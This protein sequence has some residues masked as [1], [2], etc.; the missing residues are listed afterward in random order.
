MPRFLNT[1]TG[2][3]EW[4]SDPKNA[5]Y[6]ILSH[7]WRDAK[8]GGE[9]T[10]DD[11]RRIQE[12]VRGGRPPATNPSPTV[13]R[14]EDTI[15]AHPDLSDKIK[16][17]CK[18]AREAGFDWAWN[19][20]CCI[21]KTS[22]AELSEAINS[23]YEL[24]KFSDVC[25]V[26]LADVHHESNGNIKSLFRKSRWHKRGWT[27][28][29]L[30]AP[31]RVEFLTRDWTFLGTKI[32]L[33]RTLSNITGVDVNILT[34]RA[35]VDSASVAQRML[36]A[37][38]RETTRI[39]DRSYSLMGLF[40][41][42]MPTI[43]GEGPNAF[44]RLQEE[45]LRTVPDHSLFIW[46]GYVR[47]PSLIFHKEHH[48]QR[49]MAQ[50]DFIIP[51][52]LDWECEDEYKV[53]LL[54][55]G[56]E[57]ANWG[58]GLL[59][60]TDPGTLRVLWL[61][62]D[63]SEKYEIQLPNDVDKGRH[64]GF[65]PVEPLSDVLFPR[66]DAM[67][68]TTPTSDSTITM[69]GATTAGPAEKHLGQKRPREVG[70]DV[71]PLESD[72]AKR[73]RLDSPRMESLLEGE[74][75][76]ACQERTDP[77]PSRME[78][79]T[80]SSA[81]RVAGSD[82]QSTT[83]SQEGRS[84]GTRENITMM[85]HATPV[86][87]PSSCL[88]NVYNDVDAATL[89]LSLSGVRSFE[90]TCD[91]GSSDKPEGYESHQSFRRDPPPPAINQPSNPP[92]IIEP[93][94]RAGTW[95]VDPAPIHPLRHDSDRLPSSTDIPSLSRRSP[96]IQSGGDASLEL[97]ESN[98]SFWSSEIRRPSTGLKR[99]DHRSLGDRVINQAMDGGDDSL[100]RHEDSALRAQIELLTKK[101][102]ELSSAVEALSSQNGVLASQMATVLARLD[103]QAASPGHAS[104]AA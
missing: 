37:S 33:A 56:L 16:G 30:L 28:Q 59:D 10:F 92:N 81:G 94:E 98:D 21:D 58:I 65:A 53:R 13:Y 26:Y 93:S 12:A 79:Q 35:T 39:E 43:Y 80:N 7:V 67:I 24:Y 38:Q 23:M 48:M 45:I 52:D 91:V 74:F 103:A 85:S 99:G 102:V 19:D 71:E 14:E 11:V 29:E 100:S 3:F 62:I 57:W 25:Y 83:F 89:L 1:F 86:H 70:L 18:V 40:G 88:S 78:S 104:R 27:L 63:L 96:R 31:E 77:H 73:A 61:T 46:G 8:D 44:L 51:A 75:T 9:Q 60:P 66:C 101:N 47:R 20:A 36:W 50:T 32:G 55:L 76:V 49:I 15:F 2:E 95:Y 4:H 84:I 87:T 64:T 34:G 22:S 17:F 69:L 54:R 90:G 5:I 72:Q 42:H 41:V 6:A 68:R 82:C 97:P